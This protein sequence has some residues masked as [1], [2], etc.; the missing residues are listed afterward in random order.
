MKKAVAVQAIFLII[1]VMIFL[2][3]IAAIFFQ[4]IDVTKWGSDKAACRAKIIN[5]CSDWRKTGE[6]KEPGWWND[7][8]VENCEKPAWKDCQF[9]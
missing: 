1:A 6:S 2:F 7:K 5:Y 9:D 4:W 3:F 8:P